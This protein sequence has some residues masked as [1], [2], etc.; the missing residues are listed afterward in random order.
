MSLMEVLEG[1]SNK[2]RGCERFSNLVFIHLGH[3]FSKGVGGC[4]VQVSS[5]SGFAAFTGLNL[6]SFVS[7][8]RFGEDG[9]SKVSP[10]ANLEFKVVG[11][12]AGKNCKISLGIE[13]SGCVGAFECFSKLLVDDCWQ[14]SFRASSPGF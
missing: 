13:C 6:P 10:S 8:C 5:S 9:I 11:S 7:F 12:Y 3:H 1:R 14:S 2:V 4:C